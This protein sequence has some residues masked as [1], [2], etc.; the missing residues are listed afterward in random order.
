[1]NFPQY[2]LIVILGPTATGKTKLAAQ[3]AYEYG[4]EIISADSRQVY[5]RMDIGTGKDYKDYVV[6]NTTIPYHL[7]DIAEPSDEYNLF[8]FRHDFYQVFNDVS[9]RGK[10]PLLTGGTGLYIDAI[11]KNYDL[12][13]AE[14]DP[15]VYDQLDKEN[16]ETLRDKLLA[17]APALH[18]T[19][20]LIDK[21]RIIRRIIVLNARLESRK[22]SPANEFGAEIKA[23]VL[24]VKLERAIV[25]QRITRRLDERLQ[26]GMI[27]EVQALLDEG[28]TFEKLAFFGLEYKF[29]GEYLEGKSTYNEMFEKLNFAIHRFSKRQM[30]WFRKIER[31]G[32]VINWLNGP[33]F[34]GAKE[35]LEKHFF[36]RQQ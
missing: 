29:V 24:G 32:T 17:M 22:E 34:P 19:S 36:S 35:L 33:D 26:S 20:D 1:M 9:A 21:D 18:N 31:E 4:G 10:L 27:E 16:I 30:T 12:K 25:K 11:L 8:R 23:L 6:N 28:I 13:K 2:N 3:L 15:V 5:R 7:I 14:I